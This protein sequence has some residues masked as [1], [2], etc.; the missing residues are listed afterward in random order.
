MNNKS[1]YF[2]FAQYIRKNFNTKAFRV[3]IDA[4]FGCKENCIYCEKHYR[5]PSE[6]SIKTQI[7]KLI[8]YLKSR[9]GA[10]D[11]YLY[12][13]KGTNTDAS[14]SELKKLYDTALSYRDFIGLIIGTRPDYINEGKIDII[15]SYTDK[16]DTWIEYGLQ[17]ANNYTLKKINRNHTYEDFLT[18][19]E[20]TKKTAIKVTVH[21]ILGLPGEN[22]EDMLKTVKKMSKLPIKGIK[23]H[24][25]YILKNTPLYEMYQ[26]GEYEP[27]DYQSYK[28]ILMEAIQYLDKDVVVHRIM[29][30]DYSDKFVGPKW[31]KSK[32]FIINDIKKTMLED[33][34]Y[35]G[36]KYKKIN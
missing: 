12:F 29:G 15:N 17:S 9:Y 4:G 16:Y 18:A 34:Y 6:E 11:F 33:N 8:P 13:Q 10:K 28:E 19:V 24:H 35:Q 1:P 31:N 26:K 25:L 5:K 32:N 23:F 14:A 27:I 22:R 3:S 7:D 21:L 2:T 36:K 30:E 20:M